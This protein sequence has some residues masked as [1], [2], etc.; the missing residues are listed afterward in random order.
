MI[1][2]FWCLENG[3][4]QFCNEAH[5]SVISLLSCSFLSSSICRQHHLLS[6]S[7]IKN[8]ES[9]R[10]AGAPGG[11]AEQPAAP[12]RSS[13]AE[14]GRAS[15]THNGRNTRVG[16][17]SHRICGTSLP[18][19]VGGSWVEAQRPLINDRLL[20]LCVPTVVPPLL[21]CRCAITR[22]L[23][24]C[25]DELFSASKLRCRTGSAI[26]VDQ[27][28]NGVARLLITRRSTSPCRPLTRRRQP[29]RLAEG[30]VFLQ[31]YRLADVLQTPVVRA[32][33][34]ARQRP[35]RCY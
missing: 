12:Q 17:L 4:C 6:L 8:T 13:V 20:L 35:L 33:R 3:N 22:P 1:F 11:W 15:R 25:A 32:L 29:R 2:G 23:L 18:A 19:L 27:A 7:H 26:V 30:R 31:K 34:R 24:P 10:L 28:Y 5:D 21:H 14:G 16:I 9:W